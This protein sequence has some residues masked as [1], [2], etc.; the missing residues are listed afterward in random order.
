MGLAGGIVASDLEQIGQVLR[1]AILS[2]E[3]G[4]EPE[5]SDHRAVLCP[6]GEADA[7]VD[8]A[9]HLVRRPELCAKLGANARAAAKSEFTW[10]RHVERLW[11]FA[12]QNSKCV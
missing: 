10:S 8:A 3:L 6:P 5:A 4:S 2:S 7:F 12:K 1:P 11:E 9:L